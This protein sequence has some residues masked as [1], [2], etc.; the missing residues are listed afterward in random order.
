MDRNHMSG[1]GTISIPDYHCHTMLCRHASGLPIEYL[2]CAEEKGIPELACTDHAPA[3]NGY[4]PEHR[5]PYETFPSYVEHVAEAREASKTCQVLL[6]V[7]AD[8]YPGCADFL[9]D[10]LGR[11]P[12]DLVLGSVHYLDYWNLV[13]NSQK[14][15]W[16]SSDMD[17]VWREYFIKVTALV[18]SGLYDVLAH[19]DLP[20][21]FG[22]K[23]SE[24]TQRETVLPVLDLIAK[25]GMAIEINTSGLRHPISEAYPSPQILAWA[26][27]RDIPIVFGSD[28]HSPRTVGHSFAEALATARQAGYRTRAQYR[29][30]RLERVPLPDAP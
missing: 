28:A 10:W 27:E 11:Y 12:F 8:Y 22:M 3:W 25:S 2:Q 24:V 6:G 20:K 15:V 9:H 23:A 17:W 1:E 21:R 26:C 30:R 7:E 14:G 29:Q 19:F 4:D 5:M 16:V 13:S 18:E